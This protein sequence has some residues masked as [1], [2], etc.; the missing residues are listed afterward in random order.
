MPNDLE[1]ELATLSVFCMHPREKKM[2]RYRITDFM[3]DQSAENEA[4]SVR[5]TGDERLQEHMQDA[6][7]HFGPSK[8]LTLAADERFAGKQV[9]QSFMDACPILSKEE[10]MCIE[11]LQS[12]S[13]FTLPAL[14]HTAGRADLSAFLQENP[15]KAPVLDYPEVGFVSL[16]SSLLSN[17]AMPMFAA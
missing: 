8:D 14:E 7:L 1:H 10:A 17:R 16:F 15:S 13:D 3:K 4:S 12:L 5:E 9:V 6:I 11:L 2:I